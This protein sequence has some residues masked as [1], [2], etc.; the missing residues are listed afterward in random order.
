MTDRPTMH[1][2]AAVTQPLCHS[3]L[4][5][6]V[7]NTAL[8]RTSDIHKWR[9]WHPISE[10]DSLPLIA[11]VYEILNQTNNI[12]YIGSAVSLC[13]RRHYTTL[14]AGKSHNG[15]LQKDF[16]EHGEGSFRFRILDLCPD[17]DP[18][19]VEQRRIDEREFKTLYNVAPIAG[20]TLGYR[21][22]D[23]QVQ[24]AGKR[25]RGVPVP[26]ETKKRTWQ[27]SV[28]REFKSKRYR[29]LLR[30]FLKTSDYELLCKQIDDYLVTEHDCGKP[31]IVESIPDG[32][33][34]TLG[35]KFQTWWTFGGGREHA[36]AKYCFSSYGWSFMTRTEAE[37]K[38]MA[39]NEHVETRAKTVRLI[40]E[41]ILNEEFD[42]KID[43]EFNQ[44]VLSG[45]VS[46]EYKP[47]E[48]VDSPFAN[49]FRSRSVGKYDD[50]SIESV[51]QMV[52]HA[53]CRQE[54]YRNGKPR[55]ALIENSVAKTIEKRVW[56]DN[57]NQQ[58]LM[59][60][61]DGALHG[62]VC[63]WKVDGLVIY[64]ARYEQGKEMEQ[65]S[66]NDI[67][68]VPRFSEV[69]PRPSLEEQSGVSISIHLGEEEDKGIPNNTPDG[70]RQPA[71]GLP[72]PSM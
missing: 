70:I 46:L 24:E 32:R 21:F 51:W 30:E 9:E 34:I 22:T 19:P 69:L 8:P 72:K 49:M 27:K 20:S 45:V 15:R 50:G 38:A 52:G 67:A 68:T 1:S 37:L 54:W 11:G 56:Y 55:L 33:K 2:N 29:K 61:V 25:R 62:V 60:F 58:C 35:K 7:G 10:W 71:N 18:V 64:A 66:S 41:R 40:A 31:V 44:A 28:E 47:F 12:S 57:G 48:V 65:L 42:P 43:G 17:Q 16:R 63:R 26:Y 59:N 5:G 13:K 14:T 23:E 36:D 39:L 3:P 4:N 6:A 53:S